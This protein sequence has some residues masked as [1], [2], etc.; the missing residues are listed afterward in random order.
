ML[1]SFRLVLALVL[2]W[3]GPAKVNQGLADFP[4]PVSCYSV[5]YLPLNDLNGRDFV[6]V[7]K[8]ETAFH[9]IVN[10]LHVNHSAF[11]VLA[12]AA[13]WLLFQLPT[14]LHSYKR[15]RSLLNGTAFQWRWMIW[16]SIYACML[17]VLQV[18]ANCN[19][20]QLVLVPLTLP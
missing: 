9:G 11:A 13:S 3:R 20:L 1:H 7:I 19:G 2:L 12:T 8:V 14:R 5:R 17:H 10:C 18:I 15:G 16:D 4:I 6:A